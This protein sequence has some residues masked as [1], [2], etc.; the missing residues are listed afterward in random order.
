M[1]NFALGRYN[2]NIWVVCQPMCMIGWS[3]L[4]LW[5]Y[6]IKFCEPSWK[7][8]RY[9]EY[10]VFHFLSL[11]SIFLEGVASTDIF[12]GCWIWWKMRGWNID[13]V[14]EVRGYIKVRDSTEVRVEE[15]WDA[16]KRI[17][18]VKSPSMDGVKV[19]MLKA[20]K[21]VVA[22]SMSRLARVCLKE[23]WVPEDWQEGST[24]PI[25]NRKDERSDCK[26]C[27]GT[28]LLS[29][30]RKVSGRAAVIEIIQEATE[31]RMGEEQ[32]G[33]RRAR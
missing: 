27:R 3:L 10:I 28:S 24:V 6:F 23:R 31:W 14:M 25:Y 8:Q 33:F 21:D 26:N 30:P 22:E 29:I 12:N 5:G 9:G 17:I 4:L 15:V 18:S 13:M 7:L 2:I 1:L 32:C 20:G 11:K 16:I 19:E